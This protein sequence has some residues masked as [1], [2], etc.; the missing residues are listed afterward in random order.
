ML[1][2]LDLADQT[3][4]PDDLVRMPAEPWLFLSTA[5]EI[6]TFLM[7]KHGLAC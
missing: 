5:T 3:Q 2:K 7:G 1:T 4:R 6:R